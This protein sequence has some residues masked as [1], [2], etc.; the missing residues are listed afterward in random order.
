MGGKDDAVLSAYQTLGKRAS[1]FALSLASAP[2]HRVLIPLPTHAL[3]S[4]M[5]EERGSLLHLQFACET[6]SVLA[7]TSDSSLGIV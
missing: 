6:V 7:D 5:T 3:F 2:F 4:V 1:L